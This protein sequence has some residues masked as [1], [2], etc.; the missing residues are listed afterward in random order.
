MGRHAEVIRDLEM[1]LNRDRTH[2]YRDHRE[3]QHPSNIASRLEEETL[4]RLPA[5]QRIENSQSGNFFARC[6]FPRRHI[7]FCRRALAASGGSQW[8]WDGWL[9]S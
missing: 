6:T 8:E 1:Y 3:A 9:G 4:V 5:L 2:G 7:Q